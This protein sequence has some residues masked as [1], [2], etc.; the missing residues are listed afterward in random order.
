MTAQTLYADNI[1]ILWTVVTSYY[2]MF[3]MASAFVYSKGY[4]AGHQ[5]VHKVINDSLEN[6]A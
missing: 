1:S 5:I 6:F 3:Y 2:A 4:K